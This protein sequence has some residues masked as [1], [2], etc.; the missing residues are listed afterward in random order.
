MCRHTDLRPE[1]ATPDKM[2]DGEDSLVTEDSTGESQLVR[3][4]RRF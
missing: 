1:K 4:S 2:Q 3:E